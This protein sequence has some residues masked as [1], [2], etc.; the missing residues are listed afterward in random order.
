MLSFPIIV[1]FVPGE[2]Y[3]VECPT[4]KGCASQGKTRAEALENVSDAIASY[5]SVLRD[6]TKDKGELTRI[7]IPDNGL[8]PSTPS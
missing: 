1:T 8:Y 2:G 6:L 5:L 4:L 7:D 3:A